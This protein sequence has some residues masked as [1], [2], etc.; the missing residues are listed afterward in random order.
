MVQSQD[1]LYAELSWL[2]S[3]KVQKYVAEGQSDMCQQAVEVETLT[4]SYTQ[5]GTDEGG[6]QIE[7]D[8]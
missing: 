6:H 5:T 4:V 2:R 8:L 7:K 3:M 1:T